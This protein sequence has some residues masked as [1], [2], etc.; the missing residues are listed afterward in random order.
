MSA[1]L[2]PAGLWP[3]QAALFLEPVTGTAASPWTGQRQDLVRA[4]RWVA[5]L[6]FDLRGA[7]AAALDALLAGLRGP[8]GEVLVP[9]WGHRLP[10]GGQTV[11][12]QPVADSGWDDGTGWADDTG[13]ISLVAGGLV[14]GGPVLLGGS[15]RTVLLGGLAPGSAAG[16]ARGDGLPTA[17]GRLHV[18]TA[19]PPP[20][21]A[22]GRV[23]VAVA[24][25]LREPVVPGL[26]ADTA[27]VR[28]RLAGDDAARAAAVPP[29]RRQFRL[30]L[31]EVIPPGRV[32]ACPRP[33]AARPA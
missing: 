32:G 3:V 14:P 16:I 15:C 31:V 19:P 12:W 17:P 9:A 21:D 6:S 10:R 26:L 11:A 25:P 8:A 13:W 7:S 23:L 30:R 22:A 1:L 5:E 29:T 27:T 2:W 28:M 20:A 24:P 33:G 4:D 18:V